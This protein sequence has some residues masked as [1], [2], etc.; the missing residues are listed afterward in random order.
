MISDIDEQRAIAK[1]GWG[2]DFR[3]TGPND[4]WPPHGELL[5]LQAFLKT[6]I[7]Q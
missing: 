5:G 4:F 1:L 7:A 3:Y 6:E 2:G